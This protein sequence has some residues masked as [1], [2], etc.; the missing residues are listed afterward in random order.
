[1]PH[2]SVPVEGAIGLMGSGYDNGT[3][4]NMRD[5]HRA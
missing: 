2:L 3:K 1:M 4:R 5:D